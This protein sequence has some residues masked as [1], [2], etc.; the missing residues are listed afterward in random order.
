M[1]TDYMYSIFLCSLNCAL[2]SSI[3]LNRLYLK[4]SFGRMTPTVFQPTHKYDILSFQIA[5]NNFS[6]P[7]SL[8]LITITRSV[9]LH[10][11][12]IC[13]INMQSTASGMSAYMQ[14]REAGLSYKYA[15]RYSR[16]VCVY[17]IC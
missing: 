7:V 13:I 4:N 12:M 6:F 16:V 14:S 11:I 17:A 15:F 1:S 2:I 9:R 3:S 5:C 8:H 10:I